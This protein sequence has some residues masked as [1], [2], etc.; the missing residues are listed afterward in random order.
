MDGKW[1]IE[2][3]G[4][5]GS[6]L[7]VVSMLM[8]SVVRLRIVNTVGSLIFMCYALIIGSY[9]TALMNLFLIGINVYQ[10]T[11]LLRDHRHYDLIETKPGDGY[12]SYFLSKNLEDIQTWFPEFSADGLQADTVL[13]VCC[14]SHPAGLFIG[15]QTG[16]NG[17][18]ILLDYTTPSYRDTSAGRFLHGQLKKKGYRTLLFRG[19]APGHVDYMEK[20]GYTKNEKGEYVL[21]LSAHDPS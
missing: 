9:P 21:D 3:V 15:R 5:I 20:L 7:V 1:I 17:I 11:R 16:Q 10:L 2:M 18:E 4:Y 8:T 12:A 6:A 13:I 14:D 19:N